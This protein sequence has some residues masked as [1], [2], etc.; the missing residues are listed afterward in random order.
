[1][2]L[3]DALKARVIKGAAID[4]WEHEPELT[5]GLADLENIIITPHTASATTEARQQMS[6][7]AAK[8]II[9]ALGGEPPP[10]LVK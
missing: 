1:M 2:A 10:D 8:N 5:P 4:V 3:R 9:A 6:E 7:R